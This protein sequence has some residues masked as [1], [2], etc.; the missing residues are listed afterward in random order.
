MLF[1]DFHVQIGFAQ[2]IESCCS[3]V[4]SP[5]SQISMDDFKLL[6]LMIDSMTA[7]CVSLHITARQENIYH[8]RQVWLFGRGYVLVG[9]LISCQ[10]WI[11][12]IRLHFCLSRLMPTIAKPIYSS[13][14]S[15]HLPTPFPFSGQ[16]RPFATAADLL[17]PSFSF[18][19]LLGKFLFNFNLLFMDLQL[20]FSQR[21]SSSV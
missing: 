19:C 12:F 5:E 8:V 3:Y 15:I 17:Q 10:S 2:Q 4:L 13:A 6:R 7:V 9:N 1:W 14:S 16:L 20:L 11:Y 18:W 21:D